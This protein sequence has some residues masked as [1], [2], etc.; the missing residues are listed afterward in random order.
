M[1]IGSI[2]GL[3][4]VTSYIES[5]AGVLA[6]GRTGLTAIS[7]GFYFGMS[8]FFAPILSSVPPWATGG[9]LIVVGSMMFQS[10]ITVLPHLLRLYSCPLHTPLRTVLSVELWYGS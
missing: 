2:F 3:S 7:T 4:P 10:L 5:G 9:A 8:I 1:G 6:G